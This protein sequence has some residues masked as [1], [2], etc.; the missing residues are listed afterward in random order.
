[1]GMGRLKHISRKVVFVLLRRL[2]APLLRVIAQ[3]RRVTILMFHNP[4]PTDLE[5]HL[6][7]LGRRYS[8]ISLRDY[9]GFRNGKA[10]LPTRPLV[11]TLDDGLPQTRDTLDVFRRHGVTPT[12]FIATSVVGTTRQYWW[13]HFDPLE[14]RAL[15]KVS[16]RERLR[17]MAERGLDES[18]E[19]DT[20]YTL[21]AIDIAE[22]RPTID[23]QPHTRLHPVLT[24][25][26]DERARR[27]IAGS[28]E[29]ARERFGIEGCALAYP[30]GAYSAR[31]QRMAEEAGFAVA[32]TTDP[33]Y[34]TAHTPAFELRRMGVRDNASVDELL[35]KASGAPAAFY[36]VVPTWV[37]TAFRA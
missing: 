35:T 22:M 37:R 32:V 26:D 28:M 18:E 36:R 11:I 9:V 30:H 13:M 5:R 7:E 4:T 20:S 27:E 3:R 16:N 31:E 23:F 2:V 24:A 12:V 6:S 1:M 19:Y 21:S 15:K 14:Q 25:C 10:G 17:V 34:N 29:E 8:F 33:G